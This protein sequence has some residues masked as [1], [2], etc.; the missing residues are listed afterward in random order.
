MKRE[1]AQALRSIDRAFYRGQAK[2]FAAT[3]THPWSGFAPILS[4]ASRPL[5]VLDVGCGNGRFMAALAQLPETEVL[6]YDGLDMSP[7]LLALAQARPRAFPC[8]FWEQ[9]VL[10]DDWPGPPT[11]PYSLIVVLGVLHHVPSREARRRLLLTLGKA[12]T[13]HG[14]LAVS[15]F[16]YDRS[17]RIYARRVSPQE[18]T[19]TLGVALPD[20]EPGD[21]LLPFGHTGQL[22]YCHLIDDSELAALDQLPGLRA[23]ARFTPASGADRLNDY[24]ILQRDDGLT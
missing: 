12:L 2:A 22:R 13:P 23:L 7:E 18:A 10:A 19:A 14:Q 9:D 8:Q 4:R 16:R 5:A 24:L 1:T 17:P 15:F 20:P 3:R 21:F 6:R 11:G